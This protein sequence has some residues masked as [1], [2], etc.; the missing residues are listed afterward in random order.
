MTEHNISTISEGIDDI[1][2]RYE[3]DAGTYRI[4]EMFEDRTRVH[5]Q[6]MFA[7]FLRED[8][9]LVFLK[10]QLLSKGKMYAVL[11]KMIVW[12]HRAKKRLDIGAPLYVVKT[13][14]N[15]LSGAVYL[16]TTALPVFEF[17]C[18]IIYVT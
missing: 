7:V 6:M 17:C 9:S 11:P 8:T 3:I 15:Q 13:F 4:V 16:V 12:D 18:S 5:D 1:I 10:K 14:L 2:M